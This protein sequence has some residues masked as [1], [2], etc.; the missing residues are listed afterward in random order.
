VF[1]L[2]VE[3]LDERALPSVVAP[4]PPA[5]EQATV[6]FTPPIGSNKGSFAGDGWFE[7]RLGGQLTTQR[8]AQPNGIIAI[9]IGL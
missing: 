3:A 9:L 4:V 6:A 5:S 7:G 2:N 8:P 1:R